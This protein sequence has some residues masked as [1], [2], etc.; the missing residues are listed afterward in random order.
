[1]FKRHIG[2]RS[3]RKHG[4]R[5]KASEMAVGPRNRDHGYIYVSFRKR[6]MMDKLA[7]QSKEVALELDIQKLNYELIL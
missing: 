3:F 2:Y 1:M 5:K 7:E 6:A 4:D